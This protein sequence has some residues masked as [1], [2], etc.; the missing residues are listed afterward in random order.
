MRVKKAAANVSVEVQQEISRSDS[1]EVCIDEFE[2]ISKV[3]KDGNS[4]KQE[5]LKKEISTKN[6]VAPEGIDYPLDLWFLIS[7]YISP[8]TTGKFARICR[9]TYYVV[10]TGKFWSHLYKSFYMDVPGL[11]DCLQPHCMIYQY[12]LRA[13]VI[14][15]LHYTYFALR[16]EKN[17]VA[18]LQQ[19]DPHSLVKRQCCLEYL[20]CNETKCRWYFFFK[21]KEITRKKAIPL[22]EKNNKEILDDIMINPEEKCKLLRVTCLKYIKIPHVIGMILHK[23]SI[24]LMPGF[25]YQRVQFGFGTS[26]IPNSSLCQVILNEVV[27][28]QI[29]DWWHPSYPHRNVIS[30]PTVQLE[31]CEAWDY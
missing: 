7:E 22:I 15:T 6:I 26:D 1:T 10:S 17:A 31:P 20:M 9:S 5:K 11:P 23:V 16:R 27:D 24:S 12:G 3:K 28:Y 8:E 4:T 29:L 14:R 18:C 19:A 30:I 13:C 2:K 25:K 21:L